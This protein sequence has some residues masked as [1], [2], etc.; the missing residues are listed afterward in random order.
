MSRRHDPGHIAYLTLNGAIV[1]FLLLPIAVVIVFA[2][3]PTPYIAFPPVGVSL[4]WFEKF[5]ASPEFMNA[6]WLSL[7]IAG[8]VLLLVSLAIVVAY[9]RIL[10]RLSGE[11]GLA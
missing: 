11:Q 4:R 2:L 3:N 5:F 8:V 6:L 9:N 7:W 10:A 1:A